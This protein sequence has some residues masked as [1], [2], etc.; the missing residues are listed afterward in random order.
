MVSMTNPLQNDAP[1][2]VAPSVNFRLALPPTLF[3]YGRPWRG[4]DLQCRV[5]LELRV[6]RDFHEKLRYFQRRLEG[7]GGPISG[8]KNG[9]GI[10]RTI[11][12]RGLR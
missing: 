9:A 2:N 10:I 6:R 4:L 12:A 5:S 11:H 3:P 7:S 8:N 1:Q